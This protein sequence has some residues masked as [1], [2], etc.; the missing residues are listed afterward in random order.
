MIV[1]SLQTGE[2]LESR[3][4]G[5]WFTFAFVFAACA[6]F[7]WSN[8]PDVNEAHYLGKALHYWN[9]DWCKDDFFLNSADAHLVFYWVFGW[10]PAIV[11]LETASIVGRVIV[12][13]LLSLSWLSVCRALR[14]D[15]VRTVVAAT[16]W[17]G[18]V[19]WCHLSG[20]WVVGGIEAKGLSLPF[21]LWG[22]AGIIR[23]Q[24]GRAYVLLGIATSLHVLVGGWTFAMAGLSQCFVAR[25]QIFTGKN[26]KCLM[27]GVLLALPGLVPALL[28]NN[29]A[30]DG[31][32]SLA[33]E[34]YVFKR[35]SHHLVFSSFSATR[36]SLGA[37]LVLVWL[38]WFV[39]RNRRVLVDDCWKRWDYLVF[40]SILIAAF[41]LLLSVALAPTQ[42]GAGIL[43]Y[44]W[45]RNFDVFVPAVIATSV[46]SLPRM[47]VS[48]QVLVIVIVCTFMGMEQ[49]ERWR[50]GRS[51]AAQQS[52]PQSLREDPE[53]RRKVTFRIWKDWVFACRWIRENTSEDAVVLTPRRQQTFKWHAHRAEVVNWKDIPQDANGLLEWNRRMESVY[54]DAVIHKG[55]EANAKHVHE[56]TAEYPFDYVVATHFVPSGDLGWERVYPGAESPTR[57][58]SSL[59][60]VYKVKR[61]QT[62]AIVRDG[63]VK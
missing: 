43:R 46:A 32:M 36:V 63:R 21:A 24:W 28:L 39:A 42:S 34:I 3:A 56:I 25:D 11:G 51:L 2:R 44:Y 9:P 4:F 49:R 31:D 18:L 10:V 15:A 38:G 7:G 54:T 59:Y 35:L 48:L 12:W 22:A 17:F 47:K 8:G 55:L 19:R 57:V 33:N 16:L 61:A 29:S 1:S 40:G 37:G 20:E 26:I 5:Y 53:A 62:S 52:M 41:G 27:C 23:G 45:F 13:V 6:L 50:D 60:V 14:L 30:S 58:R